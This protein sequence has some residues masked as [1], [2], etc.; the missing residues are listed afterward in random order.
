MS[1]I[2]RF[3][4]RSV[5]LSVVGP[6]HTSNYPPGSH[7]SLWFMFHSSESSS[8]L[9]LRTRYSPGPPCFHV[10]HLLLTLLKS[11]STE[12]RHYVECWVC[13]LCTSANSWRMSPS[14]VA[15]SV[16]GRFSLRCS[17]TSNL[18]RRSEGR[19]ARI[20]GHSSLI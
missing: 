20:Y 11:S 12:I 4:F 6:I 1:S 15:V 13:L 2:E 10:T 8:V 3:S 19:Q 5:Y 9:K 16:I 14:D 18:V 17:L 7:F